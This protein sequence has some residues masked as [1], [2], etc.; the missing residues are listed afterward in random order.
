MCEHHRITILLSVNKHWPSNLIIMQ[1]LSRNPKGLRVIIMTLITRCPSLF[2]PLIARVVSGQA[3]ALRSARGVHEW[4]AIEFLI[5]FKHKN[6]LPTIGWLERGAILISIRLFFM[7][8]RH[9]AERRMLNMV[10]GGVDLHC[11]WVSGYGWGIDTSVA[12]HGWRKGVWSGQGLV[13]ILPKNRNPFHTSWPGSLHML[14]Y[15]S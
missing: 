12:A 10:R 3:R 6:P 15:S 11:K 14:F 4:L 8:T 7:R 13:K 1:I 5:R 9:T 2:S